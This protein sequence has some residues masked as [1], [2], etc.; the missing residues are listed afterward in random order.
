MPEYCYGCSKLTRVKDGAGGTTYGCKDCPGLV[1]GEDAH[2][3]N[4]ADKPRPRADDC[5][6][7][8]EEARPNG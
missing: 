3:S 1:L 5:F 7:S 8:K 2:W 6:S 4:D